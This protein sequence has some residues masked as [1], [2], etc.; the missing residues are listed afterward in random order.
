DWCRHARNG[1]GEAHAAHSTPG[2]GRCPGTVAPA[3]G[4]GRASDGADDELL[5][6]DGRLPGILPGVVGL[7]RGTPG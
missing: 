6:A 2:T 5:Q 3:D 7:Q 4:A 1:K